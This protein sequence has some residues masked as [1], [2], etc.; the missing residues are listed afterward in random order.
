MCDAECVPLDVEQIVERHAP[1]ASEQHTAVIAT[2][3]FELLALSL[4]EQL[5]EILWVCFKAKGDA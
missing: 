4:L 1:F 5:N 2:W 3:S